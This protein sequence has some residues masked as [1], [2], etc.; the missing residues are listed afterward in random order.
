MIVERESLGLWHVSA[1]KVAVK[2][3]RV[4]CKVKRVESVRTQGSYE[5]LGAAKVPTRIY[6]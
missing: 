6:I 2:D 3:V 5:N 1:K 4:S